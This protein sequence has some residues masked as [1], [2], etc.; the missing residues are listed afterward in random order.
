M[1]P[2]VSCTPEVAEALSGEAPVVALESTII[3][4][5]MPWPRNMETALALEA[6]IRALG[7]EPATIAIV[8]GRLKAGLSHGEIEQLARDAHNVGK[9]SRRD[10]A[11][12]VARGGTGATTVA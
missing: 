10:I 8:E 6:E 1:H 5:G 9:V 2:L 11:S 7:A 12:V 4:H 3:A